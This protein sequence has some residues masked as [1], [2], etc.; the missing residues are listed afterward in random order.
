MRLR[1]EN[2][3]WSDI[4]SHSEVSLYEPERAEEYGVTRTEYDQAYYNA[5][6]AIYENS[7]EWFEAFEYYLTDIIE[8][9]DHDDFLE[10]YGPAND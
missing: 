8:V 4:H 10:Y 3:V 2:R 5:F 1:D 9:Y 6:V 7:D